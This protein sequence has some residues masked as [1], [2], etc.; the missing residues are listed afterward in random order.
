MMERS[1]YVQAPDEVVPS[2]GDNKEKQVQPSRSPK[3]HKKFKL[4]KVEKLL[5][6]FF[7]VTI[8]LLT[9]FTIA[10]KNGFSASQQ[11]LQDVNQNVEKIHNDNGNLKQEIS[12]LQSSSRLQ[13]IAQKNGLSL[14]NNNIRNVRK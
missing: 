8:L 1:M 6:S 13:S 7:L 14:S 9:L 2:G 4:T 11:D 5:Y 3:S 10:A 12:E